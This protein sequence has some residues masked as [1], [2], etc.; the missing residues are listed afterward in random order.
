MMYCLPWLYPVYCNHHNLRFEP[1]KCFFINESKV[2]YFIFSAHFPFLV[3]LNKRKNRS[4]G[5]C[6]SKF[7]D[8][9]FTLHTPP[10]TSGHLKKVVSGIWKNPVK[11]FATGIHQEYGYE[12]I[13][14]SIKSSL[15]E[16]Y[17][18]FPSQT[19]EL[20]DGGASVIKK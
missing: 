15:M 14:Q 6:L 7:N 8:K 5:N 18:K 3:V 16:V 17:D 10:L 1:V 20:L 2:I 19:F 4:M 9:T 13:T 11:S 12:R